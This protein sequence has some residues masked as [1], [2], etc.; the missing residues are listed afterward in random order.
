M[1]PIIQAVVTIVCALV[2]SSGFWSVVIKRMDAKN[3]EDAKRQDAAQHEREAQ[4]KLLIG[5][6]HDRIISLGMTYIERGYVTQEEYENFMVYL[7]EPY[8]AYGGNGSG[9]RVAEEVK[10]LPIK[11]E[12]ISG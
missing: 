12:K 2:A 1:D 6:A 7:Y 11:K 3:E 10:K 4:R 8:S 5:L 9:A